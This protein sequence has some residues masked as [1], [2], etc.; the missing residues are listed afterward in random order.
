MLPQSQALRVAAADKPG[1]A[2]NGRQQTACAQPV[3][4]ET[5]PA[6]QNAE[7]GVTRTFVL[8]KEGRPLMPCSNARARILI[9][10][11]R[12]RVYRLFP[13]TIQL[14]DR[15]SGDVQPVVI[16]LDPGANTTG[17]ALVREHANP[18]KQTVLHLAEIG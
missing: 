17:V 8:S 10:K 14:I 18:V 3:R 13:F 15:V 12:A 6:P 7:R 5:K 11:G 2:R 16:K 9:R 1:S 4:G